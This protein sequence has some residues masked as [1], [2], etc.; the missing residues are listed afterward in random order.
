MKKVNFTAERVA[1][2]NCEQGK[3]HAIYWDR[4]TPGLGLRVTAAG[5]K[6]YIFESRLNKKTLRVTIGDIR[7]WSISKAQAK[8]TNLKSLTDK[9]MDPRQQKEERRIAADAAKLEAKRQ[10]L[11]LSEAWPEY[12]KAR[13]SKWSDG[14]YNAHIDL[15]SADLLPN[16]VR[17]RSRVCG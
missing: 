7:T 8:A 2:F 14:H 6:S 13:K 9:G 11:T 10:N 15:A 17:S 16:L 4:K 3:Q 5:A 12:L 1:G